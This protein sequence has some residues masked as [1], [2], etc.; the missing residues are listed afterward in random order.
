MTEI[1]IAPP[2]VI[3]VLGSGNMGSGIA[4]ACA[5][6][7]FRVRVRD[8]TDAQLARGRSAVERTLDGAVQRRKLTPAER[9]EV[10]QRIEF[11]TD[12]AHAV[13]DARLVIEAVFEEEAVKLALFDELGPLLAETTIVATNTSS[14]SVTRLG[15]RFP[16]PGRFAGLHFF[17]PAAINKLLEIVGGDATDPAT[18][19]ALEAFGH[20]LKK[21]PIF[22]HDAAGFA[23][24]RFFVPYMNEATRMAQEGLASLATIESVGRDLTGSSNGPF[25]VMNLTGI[26]ISYHAMQSLEAAFG[27][28]YD[29]SDLL[30]EQV[31]AGQPWAW[32]DGQVE[33]GRTQAVRERFEGALIG[34]AT[35]L[36]DEGVATPEAVETGAIVG[37]KWTRGPFGILSALGL[38]TGLERVQAFARPWGEAFPVSEG[39]AHRAG[40]GEAIWPLRW[41]RTHK[42]GA[43]TWVLL[44]RPATLNALTA[45]T[46]H[47]LEETFHHLAKDPSVRA[48]V[49]AGAG[50]TFCAGA[51]VAEMSGKSVGEGR[52][53]G[54]LGQAAC[55]AIETCPKP[56]IAFVEGHALGGG[57]EVALA[58][59]FIV[60]SETAR[61]G[62][63]ETSIGIHPGLGG[64]TRLTRLIGRARAK[65]VVFSAQSF[66][67]EEALRLG[68]VAKVLP[69]DRARAEAQ[70]LAE[71][72]AS[73]APLAV[74]AV[75]SVIDHSADSSLESALQLEGESA[76]H[77]FGTEDKVEG[78]RAFLEGRPPQF[79]GR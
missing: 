40:H 67:A 73:R 55:R 66:T 1:E 30:A 16:H 50:A 5:Q 53:F 65:M 3:A 51:D 77:T 41:V 56:V 34:I 4:Q 72:I 35:R 78:M 22:V 39:L 69:A 44:D 49:L 38:V 42:R 17:Y 8:L 68:F 33:P 36:V 27:P 37:L 12:L 48:I 7:G 54:F 21:I 18:L 47:Q 75:K 29:P 43:V 26:T 70:E 24:N 79:K 71:T 59:D 46:F 28:A 57:L 6:A 15:S 61:L 62:L 63:P 74:A 19:H 14:L 60:A 23:A 32:R 11:T 20:R 58:A 25:E 45:D 2:N 76:A 52:A 9:D 13:Q 10:L 31:K 64:A